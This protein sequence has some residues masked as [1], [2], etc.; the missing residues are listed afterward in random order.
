[1]TSPRETRPRAGFEILAEHFGAGDMQPLN[2]V[3]VD[4]TGYDAPQGLIRA[5]RARDHSGGAP[6]R[7]LRAELL[8]RVGA[9]GPSTSTGQLDTVA[10]GVRR[11]D[12][13][14]RGACGTRFRRRSLSRT[15][16]PA[17]SRKRKMGWSTW[18]ATS[19]KLGAAY[20][21]M[22]GRP[23]LRPGI[24]RAREPLGPGAAGPTRLRA[25]LQTRRRTRPWASCLKP[26]SRWS[27]SPPGP[28]LATTLGAR[29]LRHAGV[30]ASSSR[31]LPAEPRR[32]QGL[33]DAYFSTDG[34]ATRLQVVLDSGPYSPPPS[35]QVESIRQTLTAKETRGDGRGNSAVLLDLRDASDRDMTRA[36][37][38]V[39][40]GVFV[41]LLLLLRAL[42]AAI[43]LI[44]TILLSY[45]R[46]PRRDTR[47]VRRHPRRHRGHLVGTHVHVRDA[48]R[49]R[50][51]LQH[52][53]SSAGEGGGGRERHT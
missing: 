34:T 44:L 15:L 7:G 3:V 2:V 49:A 4:P 25:Q 33:R 28:R 51:G 45:A 10:A 47:A 1:V 22:V 43:Y 9:E 23:R 16:L 39:L 6:H 32:S 5:K 31:P 30:Q 50:D 21:N 48:C 11:R 20:P 40:G 35:R 36:I 27:H 19:S 18:A 17:A 41:V 52:L 53:P 37:I 13:A 42:V 46:H 29:R 26:S 38:F 14:T 12:R 24:R 8:R